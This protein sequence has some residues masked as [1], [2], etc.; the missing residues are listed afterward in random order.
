VIKFSDRFKVFKN[1]IKNVVSILIIISMM[2]AGLTKPAFANPSFSSTPGI[3]D[4]KIPLV[5][6]NK[7]TFDNYLNTYSNNEDAVSKRIWG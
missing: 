5:Q 4:S 3:T 2:V 1:T 7:K 6:E